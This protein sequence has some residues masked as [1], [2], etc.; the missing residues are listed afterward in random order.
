MISGHLDLRAELSPVTG[1]TV[2]A[3]QSFRA[4]FHLGKPYHDT[5]T[6]TLIAQI[7]NPTA[8]ILAGDE[9]RSDI[10]VGP[11]ASL[12]V[13]TPAATRIFTTPARPADNDR[14]GAS[15]PPRVAECRQRFAVES[16]GWLE[17]M[18]E[19][20]VPHQHSRY[21]QFTEVDISAHAA[22]LLF[23]DFLMPGR[24]ARGEAWAWDTLL[25]DLTIRVGN[26]LV[27]RE[28]LDQTGAE[29]RHLATLAGG[30]EGVCLGNLVLA[31]PILASG[32]ASPDTD[33][34]WTTALRQLHGHDGVWAGL[35]RLRLPGCWSLK[36]VAPDGQR[37][38]STL[39]EIRRILSAVLPHT[40]AD[41]RKL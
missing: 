13:T 29:L 36:L 33:D 7:V 3:R 24:I 9:L 41:L 4:P 6:G 28:R 19:P 20:L 26:R 14:A 22:G 37:L 8:G 21:R 12:L 39:R 16:G 17:F 31:A 32:G 15:P 18:P 40:A 1:R 34:A 35:S 5:A 38:R 23:G 25:L 2:L 10:S 30:G 11:G 27:L